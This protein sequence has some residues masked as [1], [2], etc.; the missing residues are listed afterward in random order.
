MF[1]ASQKIKQTINKINNLGRQSRPFLFIIDFGIKSPLV[2]EVD[3]IPK[4]VMF[5]TR[6][7]KNFNEVKSPDSNFHFKINP[8]AKSEY[9]KAFK[10][11]ISNIKKGNTYL[12]NLTFPSEIK[13]NLS[14]KEIF[15]ISSAPFK[16]LFRNNFVVF[17]PEIFIEIKDNKILTCPMKGT[18]D[19]SIP[20]AREKLHTNYKELAEHYTVVDLLRNDLSIVAEKVRVERFRY[21]EKIATNK[22]EILQSSSRIVGDLPV[23]YKNKL[24]ELIFKLLPAGSISG[25]PKKKT[26]EII[27]ATESYKRGFYTGVFGYFDGEELDSCVIIRFIENDNGKLI[28][29]SG[30]GIT[31]M[32]DLESEYQELIKK[33]YVP[34]N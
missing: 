32:S 27:N 12:L 17:S 15:H 7:G 20:G 21:I 19:A 29:K 23:N 22:G 8:P 18:I 25:A 26:I 10:T 3:E 34:I 31:M 16:L 33:V 2:Y 13:T 28:F 11:V 6:N 24:G 4:D 30:G 1:I 9:A 14:L 5:K